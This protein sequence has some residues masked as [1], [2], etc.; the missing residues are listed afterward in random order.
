MDGVGVHRYIGRWRNGSRDGVGLQWWPDGRVYAGTW[1]MNHFDGPGLLLRPDGVR[2]AGEWRNGQQQG[3][4]VQWGD[5]SFYIGTWKDGMADGHGIHID[6]ETTRSSFVGDWVGGS[7]TG[8]GTHID[9][10]LGKHFDGAWVANRP[11]GAGVTTFTERDGSIYVGNFKHGTQDG[12]GAVCEPSGGPSG[13]EK[14]QIILGR[15]E[16]GVAQVHLKDEPGEWIADG[17][18]DVLVRAMD[19]YAG[20]LTSRMSGLYS[21]ADAYGKGV[22]RWGEADSP[23]NPTNVHMPDFVPGATSVTSEEITAALTADL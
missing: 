15:W 6:G 19:I 11:H 14:D 4:G 8:T 20:S 5:S 22:V 3:H 12:V 13:A 1:Q 2:Y 17:G 16:N 7:R 21:Y 23:A 18:N 10:I 9:W